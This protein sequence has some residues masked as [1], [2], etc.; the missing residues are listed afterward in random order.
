ML[1]QTL[2]AIRQKS[3]PVRDQYALLFAVVSTL[4]IGGVWSLSLPSKLQ[5]TDIAAVAGASTTAPFGGIWAEF[6]SKFTPPP[7]TLEGVRL[8]T[9]SAT[10]TNT[11]INF[12]LSPENVASVN[13]SST[14]YFS[15]ELENLPVTIL[16]G[17]TSTERVSTSTP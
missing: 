13:A 16:I 12:Q 6:R 11:A 10:G 2:D 3:K 15:P 14:P 17:T 8:A 7:I 5:S 4:V 1:F 9:T